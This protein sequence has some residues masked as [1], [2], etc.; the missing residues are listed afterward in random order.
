MNTLVKYACSVCGLDQFKKLRYQRFERQGLYVSVCNNCG[1]ICL[2]PRMSEND[3]ALYYKNQYYGQYQP[4][5]EKDPEPVSDGSRAVQI[6]DDLRPWLRDSTKVLEIG[7]GPGKNLIELKTRGFAKVVGLEPS[8][9]CCEIVRSHG[10]PCVNGVLSDGDG[11]SGEF[12]FFDIL[13]LSHMVEHFVDPGIALRRMRDLLVDDGSL[14]IIVPDVY[15]CDYR[16]QFT[17]PHTF[18]FSVNTLQSLL[19]NN[20]F[21]V[22]QVFTDRPSEIALLASKGELVNNVTTAIDNDEYRKAATFLKMDGYKHRIAYVRDSI[23]WQ[24][25]RLIRFTTPAVVYKY[26]RAHYRKKAAS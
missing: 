9:E 15:K 19:L 5:P 7:C 12:G 24:M 22:R 25:S 23:E 6:S 21:T 17:I 26:I 2:N 11:I 14:Y 10:I 4:H 16:R 3:Y 8:L 20:G 18:Y 1:V 13:I